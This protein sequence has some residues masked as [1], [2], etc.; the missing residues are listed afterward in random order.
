MQ[1]IVDKVGSTGAN[2]P[3]PWTSSNGGPMMSYKVIFEGN[4]RTIV[5]LSQKPSTP[6]PKK[7][8]VLEGTIDMSNKYGP[9]FKKAFAP[10]PGGGAPKDE[11]AIRAQFA[12]KAAIQFYAALPE[13][14]RA[15]IEDGQLWIEA[16]AKEMFT[17]VDAVKGA[18]T[19]TVD[20]AQKEADDFSQAITETFGE[21]IEYITDEEGGF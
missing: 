11:S 18:A 5:E 6:A 4:P 15:G 7:G 10:R 16:R 8:D 12:I 3:K 2:A 1:Y 13:K 21:G 14:T 19:T 9:K 20:P 17:M